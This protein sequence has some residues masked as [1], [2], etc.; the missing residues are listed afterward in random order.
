[1]IDSTETP[2]HSIYLFDFNFVPYNP[3][4]IMVMTG[5]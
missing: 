2:T 3:Y 5:I 1:M 4:L